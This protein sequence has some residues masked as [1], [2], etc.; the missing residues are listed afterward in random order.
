MSRPSQS[1]SVKIKTYQKRETE[2]IAVYKEVLVPTHRSS[3]FIQA[4]LNFTCG[5]DTGFQCIRQNVEEDPSRFI[6]IQVTFKKGMK[7]A[8]SLWPAGQHNGDFDGL[9]VEC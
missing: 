4:E 8:L 3:F 2:G 5:I 1:Q 6:S 9:G 7:G